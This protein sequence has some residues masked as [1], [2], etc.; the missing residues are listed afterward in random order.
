MAS[1]VAALARHGPVHAICAEGRPALE[2]RH[3]SAQLLALGATVEICTDAALAHAL[4]GTDAVVVGADAVCPGGWVNKVGTRMLAAA[5]AQVGCP[6]Y[7]VAARD[8]FVGPLIAAALEI[9]EGDAREVWP[10]PPEG[11]HVRNPYFE[12]TPLE[13]ATQFITDTG[14][15]SPT[16]VA[17]ICARIEERISPPLVAQLVSR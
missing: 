1:V 9:R 12:V 17:A 14:V 8:K 11:I 7:V 4:V 15:L 16:D 2:G 5:A 6:V 13:L 10:D 3:Q